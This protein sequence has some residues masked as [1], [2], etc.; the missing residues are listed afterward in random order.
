MTAFGLFWIVSDTFGSFLD[1]FGRFQMISYSFQ[2]VL[3]HFETLLECF[4]ICWLII[5]LVFSLNWLINTWILGILFSS[6]RLMKELP[7]PEGAPGPD[8]GKGPEPG[9]PSG[10]G[11][12][13]MSREPNRM[14]RI[15]R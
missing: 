6:R 14:P 5:G 8:P 9:A 7:W 3:D 10:H 12:P 13:F 2:A 1:R 11:S 4:G 15:D